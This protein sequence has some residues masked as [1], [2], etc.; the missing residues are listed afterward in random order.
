VNPALALLE[1]PRPGAFSD[2]CLGKR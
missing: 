2:K 1:R